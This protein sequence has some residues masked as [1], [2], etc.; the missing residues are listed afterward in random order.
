[1]P[2]KGEILKFKN[3]HHQ[4]NHNF[5][6]IADFESTLQKIDEYDF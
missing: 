2:E 6:I 4:C 3:Y 5:H 1:M